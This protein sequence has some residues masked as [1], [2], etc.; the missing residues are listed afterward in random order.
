MGDVLRPD[1][2]GRLAKTARHRTL[3]PGAVLVISTP[4]NI[5]YLCGFDGSLGLLVLSAEGHS[6]LLDGRYESAT[7]EAQSAGEIGPVRIL[8]IGGRL[9]D[10]LAS[11]I[12]A[13]PPG[14]V[15]FEAD[16]VTVATLSDWQEACHS[17]TFRATR[18]LVEDVRAVKEAGELATIRV[19]CSRLSGVARHLGD[20]VADGR[21]ER[22]I[23]ADIDAA[24]LRAGFSRPAFPTI[25]A[26]G[27]NSAHPHARP[28]D[29]ALQ[30][31]D[32]V[33]L[34]FGG[35]LDGYCG[36]LTRMAAVGPVQA[37]ARA[38]VDAVRAA[39]DAALASVR[40]GVLASDVDKAAREVLSSRGLGEAFLHATGH[41]L[42]LEL[43]EAPRIG[44]KDADRAVP[45]EAGMVCT[46]E[47]G[48]Y[49]DGFGGARLED[50]VVVT[51]DGCDLLTDAPRELLIV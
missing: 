2:S 24:I 26:S 13:L 15:A 18:G 5:Q 21:R 19:A 30:R 1:W 20:W 38:L 6:L 35:V 17:R 12:S 9:V 50:D 33:V 44:R 29:R 27:P 7:R 40:A 10:A 25:V 23:A 42:G 43:H 34:D 22:A 11:L 31:G 32:L 49:L 36:D 46:I 8:G 39:Q 37:N 3:P 4:I 16:R 51:A 48:A 45:L 14:D 28:T 47:P 41:G